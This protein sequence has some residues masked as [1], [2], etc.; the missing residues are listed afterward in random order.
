MMKT[1]K[2]WESWGASDPYF[3][4]LT[5][6]RFR[7][8]S[9]DQTREDFFYS[10]E[11]FIADMIEQFEQ[12]FGPLSRGRAMDFGCGVGRLAI[13]LARRFQSVIGIDISRSMLAEARRNS[14]A[15]AL[16]NIHW[17]LSDDMLT[18]AG[19][20]LDYINSYIVLQHIPTKRGISMIRRMIE[21]LAPGGG[22]MLHISLKRR[23]SFAQRVAYIL[24]HH[25]PGGSALVNVATGRKINEPP[26]QM[27]EYPLTDLLD[28][29]ERAGC[30]R[31][32]CI[33]EM[34]NGVLTTIIMARK[35]R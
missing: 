24:R 13:P 15:I 35:P 7:E 21:I 26:M 10:G 31:M 12:Q 6:D 19:T 16:S 14:D 23:A 11:A 32:V 1:D 28:L 22:L 33:P 30:K 27:N 29:I 25:V 9:I 3:G 8:G 34:H 2:A 5:D 4:V 20:G 18:Q 17:G